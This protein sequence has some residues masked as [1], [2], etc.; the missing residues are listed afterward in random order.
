MFRKTYYLHSY[1]C[2]MNLSDSGILS[3]AMDMA[4][5]QMVTDP[6]QAG[7]III[8]TC[9][10]REKAEERALGRLSSLTALKQANETYICAVGCMAQRMGDDILKRIPGVDF[11]LGTERLFELPKLLENKNGQAIVDTAVSED[12]AWAEYPPQPDNS[13]SAHITITRGCNNFC[14]Y[15]IVPYVR[16]R[17]RHRSPDAII[18]DVNLMV[19]QGVLEITLIGQNVNS[20]QSGDIDFPDL[21]SRVATETDIKRL[22]FITSHPKDISDKLI[23]LFATEAK[24]MGHLHLPLQSGSDQVL[25]NM[26]RGY[27]YAHYKNRVD[28]LRIAR[29]D[30]SLTTD[31]IVGFPGETDEQ[32]RMTLNAV[33]EIGYDSAFMFRYSNRSGTYAAKNLD[34]D[35]PEEEK[36]ARLQRLIDIQKKI[37]FSV[38]QK[39]VGR[40]SEVLIDGVSR[41]DDKIL[42][43]KTAG[44]KTVLFAGNTDLIGTIAS[45]KVTA[46][47][48]WTLHGEIVK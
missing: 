48:S 32:Y 2:Q 4:G 45:V 42:K 17:E 13:F 35:V 38:N 43:G 29:P 31:L 44:N 40:S 24:L 39:E 16:G 34:D 28:L 6:K 33:E 27:S 9:S 7:V 46:A 11:I 3:S 30:I 25:K 36:L 18:G 47:D 15:C 41:R 5:Y 19:E 8:N 14:S 1:G 10:V 26:F 22:R 12:I 37:S 20:F 23:D 21:L